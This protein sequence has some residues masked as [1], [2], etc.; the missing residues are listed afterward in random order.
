[1]AIESYYITLY[2]WETTHNHLKYDTKFYVMS[3]FIHGKISKSLSAKCTLNWFEPFSR[4]DCITGMLNKL[5]NGRRTKL[6]KHDCCLLKTLW[7]MVNRNTD[8]T[9]YRYNN[10]LTFVGLHHLA[11]NFSLLSIKNTFTEKKVRVKVKYYIIIIYAFIY[12]LTSTTKISHQQ[13]GSQTT[14]C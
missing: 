14:H 13:I 5:F 6:P 9:T 4:V 12:K 11:S 7:K 2:C 3:S 8:C 1:M 10:H